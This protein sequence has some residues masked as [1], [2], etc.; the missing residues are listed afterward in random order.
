MPPKKKRRRRTSRVSA[1]K[2]PV[3]TPAEKRKKF[4]EELVEAFV[5]ISM[6]H[7]ESDELYEKYKEEATKF[8]GETKIKDPI[9]SGRLVVNLA[10]ATMDNE[11]LRKAKEKRHE[12]AQAKKKT[13]KK[14]AKTKKAT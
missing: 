13:K 1:A 14:K 12:K 3:E 2:V 8:L 7:W 11:E 6:V 5:A 9:E 10:R 4:P